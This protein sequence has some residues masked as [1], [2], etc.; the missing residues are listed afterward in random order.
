MPQD[1]R[2]IITAFIPDALYRTPYKKLAPTQLRFIINNILSQLLFFL[3]SSLLPTFPSP[4]DHSF[5]FWVGPKILARLFNYPAPNKVEYH[6]H[7]QPELELE[8]KR[9]NQIWDKACKHTYGIGHLDD[10]QP[11]I[12]LR[13]KI[14]RTWECNGA[15]TNKAPIQ[16]RVFT[17][18]LTERSTLQRVSATKSQ[19]RK[20]TS[21]KIDCKC[22][23]LLRQS[24]KIDGSV[25]Q[26]RFKLGFKINRTTPSII[27]SINRPDRSKSVITY[28]SYARERLV[29]YTKD[30]ICKANCRRTEPRT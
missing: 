8:K 23:D 10:L 15:S 9:S 5:R 11:S 21:L 12:Q 25:Q 16:S 26:V 22:W 30:T 27:S 28:S 2:Q 20:G 29:I 7:C 3:Q 4:G 1:S 6:D 24:K 14:C 19:S 18:T 13:H 17:D